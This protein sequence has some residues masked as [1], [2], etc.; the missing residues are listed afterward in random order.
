MQLKEWGSSMASSA[1]PLIPKLFVELPSDRSC[2][3][4]SAR[5]NHSGCA[6]S[7]CECRI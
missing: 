6:D 3:L 5:S 4:P 7:R 2:H 1:W